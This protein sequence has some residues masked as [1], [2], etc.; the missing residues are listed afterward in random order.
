MSKHKRRGRFSTSVRNRILSGVL[1][2]L[3]FAVTF[4]VIRWLFNFVF[5]LINP[6]VVKLVE[7]VQ[8]IPHIGILPGTAISAIVTVLTIFLLLFL[9]YLVGSVARWVIVRRFV[10]AGEMMLLK[11]PLVRTIYSATQQVVKAVSLPGKDSFKSVA[12]V[13]FP[14]PGFRSI[15]FIT[16]YIND[17]H[18][19]KYC[20][21]FIPTAPNPT[22][23]FFQLIPSEQVIETSLTVEDAFSMIISGGL[24]IPNGFQIPIAQRSNSHVEVG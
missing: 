18:G 4:L 24:V 11:I 17:V 9:L 5:K 22:T 14:R 12:M 8:E 13:E 21:V 7:R 23:G 2:L 19:K 16:G 6:T 15:G 3:P 20:R 1:L 10:E